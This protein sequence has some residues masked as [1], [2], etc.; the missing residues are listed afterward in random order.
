[1]RF[2]VNDGINQPMFDGR[3]VQFNG[4]PDLPPPSQQLLYEHFKQA[5]LANMK[6]AG[7]PRDFD[8]DDVEDAQNMSVFESDFGREWLETRMAE[9][10][11]PYEGG[12]APLPSKQTRNEQLQ[13]RRDDDGVPLFSNGTHVNAEFKN[14]DSS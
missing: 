11:A 8:F 2:F 3:V 1:M 6:G 4:T 9:K 7:Q 12:H 14:R 5:V 13:E 10:L